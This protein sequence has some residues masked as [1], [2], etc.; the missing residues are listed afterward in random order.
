MNVVKPLF[1][2][3]AMVAFHV[4][5]ETVTRSVDN[6]GNVTYSD[7]PVSNTVQEERV[8]IDAPA[9]SVEAQ[10]EAQQR[11][12]DLQNA[13]SQAGTS[14]ASDNA[15]QKK[16]SRQDAG[17]AEKHLKD[18]KQVHEGDRIGTAG[19]GSRLKP[20][21]HDRVRKAEAEAERAKN[22]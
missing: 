5:A 13:A 4:S 1:I 15:N 3:I 18:A 19:G 21:Y 6:Q 14:S 22:K 20:E 2:I 8:S 12:A 11:E 9:P 7:K 10:Q 16:A 17:D